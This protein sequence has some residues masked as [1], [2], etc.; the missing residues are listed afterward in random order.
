[1]AESTEQDERANIATSEVLPPSYVGKSVPRKEDRRLLTGKGCYTGD[2]RFPGMVHAAAVRS[3]HAHARI[4]SIDATAALAL[5]GVVAFVSMREMEGKVGNFPEPALRDLNPDLHPLIRLD[6]RS[7]PMEPLPS[8]RVLWVGQPIGYVVAADPRIAEDAAELVEVDYEVL[9]A[10]A[11]MDEATAEDAVLLHPELGTNVQQTYSVET[12]DVAG[13]LERAP[14]R[15]K[16]RLEIGRAAASAMEPRGMVS[17]YD[18]GRGELRVWSTN[19]RPHLLREMLSEMLDMPAESI[20]C[21]GPD[22][23]GSFGSGVF[24]EELAIPFLARQLERPVRWVE[25]RLENLQN[26]RHCRDQR[27]DVEVAYDDDGVITALRDDFTVDF[28]AHN[29]YA[30]TVSYNVAAHFRGPFKIDNFAIHCTGVLSNKAPAAPVRGAG[31]PEA[32]FV[33]DRV[34]DLVA[35][36]L[37]MDALEVRRRNLI[38]PED[39][40]YEMGIPYRD[41]K[42][43]TYDRGDF[44]AQLDTALDLI[45]LPYWRARQAEQRGTERRIGIGVGALM[46]GSGVGPH[47]GAIVRVDDTGAVFVSTGAQPHGQG[48]ETTLAQVVADQ[49]CVRL[50]DVTVRP[51]DTAAIAYGVGTFASRSAVTAGSAVA[52]AGAKLREKIVAVAAEVLEAEPAD[53]DIVD[54][55]VQVRGSPSSGL[56]FADVARAARPGP[57]CRVPAGM[58]PGLEEQMY[59]V[60]PTVTWA[61]GTQAAVVEVDAETGFFEL[62]DYASVDD[63]GQMLNPMIVKGQVHGGVVHGIGN[64]MLE[65]LV[66][67]PDGQL[68]TTTFADYMLPTAAEVPNIKL[69]HDTHLSELNPLGVK[70]VGEGGAVAPLAAIANAIADAFRP[71]KLALQ[72]VPLHPEHVLAAIRAAEAAQA[73]STPESERAP[74][75]R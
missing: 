71:L 45:D 23:G 11:T 48:L 30:I 55:R 69:A 17:V 59:F 67:A 42:M 25:D 44:P 61:S 46:E 27:H 70:G 41:T 24:H 43:V 6:I 10:I 73:T 35:D 7:Q 58:S 1:M 34:I 36:E 14:H 54:G 64:A 31:R 65:E 57:G 47:E 28:G 60:P 16:A 62:L 32:S 20:R 52:L 5:D 13:A 38:R 68:Q 21:L 53:L 40:P 37:G 12:G 56:S 63:C 75:S 29:H 50:E 33:M 26:T 39:M 49:L 74:N 2:L 3:A 15:L 19:I 51:T 4:A 18:A 22:I 8:E 66:Y 72:R 9:T